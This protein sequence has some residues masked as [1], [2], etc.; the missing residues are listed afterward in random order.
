[1]SQ[2]FVG[3][4]IEDVEYEEA[5]GED[6][7]GYGVDALGPVHKALADCIAV[8]HGGHWRGRRGEDCGPLHG[9]SILVLQAV[10]QAMTQTITPEVKP[11]AVSH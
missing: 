2:Y 5:Q 11:T 1:M 8:V 7:P 3:D 6:G 9:G 4:P 10:T